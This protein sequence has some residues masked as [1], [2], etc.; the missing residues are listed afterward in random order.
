[1]ETIKDNYF[2]TVKNESKN[3]VI[4]KYL[5]VIISDVNFTA[6]EDLQWKLRLRLEALYEEAKG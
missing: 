4:D 1:M 2:K 5:N 6:P 3:A